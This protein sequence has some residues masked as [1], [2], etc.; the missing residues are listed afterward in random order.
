MVIRLQAQG[1]RSI[2][3]S[4]L[5]EGV[6]LAR[7]GGYPEIQI[8]VKY[9]GSLELGIPHGGPPAYS[10]LRLVCLMH[11]GPQ[12]TR[13]TLVAGALLPPTSTNRVQRAGCALMSG[14]LQSPFP[15]R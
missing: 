7:D 10:S 13:L 2:G 9:W 14:L 8:P 11:A 1:I 6:G 15:Y 12:E 3:L 4:G 5:D